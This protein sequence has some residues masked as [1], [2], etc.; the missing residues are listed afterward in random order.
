MVRFIS[1]IVK[2]RDHG[3]PQ[4]VKL[5]GMPHVMVAIGA[6]SVLVLHISSLEDFIDNGCMSVT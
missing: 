4:A 1:Q 5:Q 3:I 2:H 6:A